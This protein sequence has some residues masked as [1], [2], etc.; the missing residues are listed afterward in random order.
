MSHQAYGAR[1][2][3]ARSAWRTVTIVIETDLEM[4][5]KGMTVPYPPLFDDMRKNH[6]FIDTRGRPE[7]ASRIANP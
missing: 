3:T 7:L 4:D 2:L 5:E 1:R 6:G